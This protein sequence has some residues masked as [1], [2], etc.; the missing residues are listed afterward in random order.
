MTL[1]SDP[2]KQRAN[3][4]FGLRGQ[5]RANELFGCLKKQGIFGESDKGLN[6]GPEA[7]NL[8]F[9]HNRARTRDLEATYTNPSKGYLS[10]VGRDY[11]RIDA[12][13]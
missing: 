3:A 13:L 5:Q 7:T 2:S 1:F 8:Y 11:A 12:M 4:L 6:C 10:A 9:A